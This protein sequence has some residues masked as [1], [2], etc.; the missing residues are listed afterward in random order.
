MPGTLRAIADRISDASPQWKLLLANDI[1][2]LNDRPDLL[3]HPDEHLRLGVEAIREGYLL[4][5]GTPRTISADTPPAQRLLIGD[6]C[7][8]TGLVDVAATG[9]V[10][11][12]RILSELITDVAIASTRSDDGA[13]EEAFSGH[14]DAALTNL[15]GLRR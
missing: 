6:F 1:E 3:D 2:A 7:Y 11:A 10:E 9:D 5:Y 4:H 8:A 15:G 13:T 14:W 12:V